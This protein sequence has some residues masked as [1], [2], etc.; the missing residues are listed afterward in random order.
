MI[1]KDVLL[2]AVTPDVVDTLGNEAT[3]EATYGV[4]LD[5][6][7]PLARIVMGHGLPEGE[8]RGTDAAGAAF[9][10]SDR[11]TRKLI[12]SCAFVG[13]PDTDGCLQISFFT[14]PAHERQGY[15]TAMAQALC[16]EAV[17]ASGDAERACGRPQVQTPAV[18]SWKRSVSLQGVTDLDEAAGFV[19]WDRSATNHF[20]R[21]TV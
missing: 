7:G 2:L 10:V 1:P 15:G 11:R 18:E 8:A 4:V 9:L 17:R 5:G 6:A 19:R 3:F 12:G 14:F 13:G 16:Q 20:T 21:L